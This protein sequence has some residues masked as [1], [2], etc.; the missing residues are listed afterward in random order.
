MKNILVA[1]IVFFVG[2]FAY[3]KFVGPIPFAV[4][5]VV[6]NK[7]DS[8]TVTGEGKVTVKPDIAVIT[9]G[10]Q[11]TGATVTAVQNN[12]NT[13]INNVSAA[14]KKAGVANK[15]IQTS[16]YS[17][18][19]TID[20]TDS[21]QHITGYQASSNLTIKI[22]AIDTANTVIDAATA[23]GAN[24]VG[25]ISFDVDDKTTSENEARTLA[26]ADAKKKAENAAATAGFKLGSIVNYQESTGGQTPVI[27][28]DAKMNGAGVATV[29][30]NVEQG[31]TD[32]TMT[33]TLSYEIR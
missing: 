22:R 4:N 18:N 32:I 21:K 33:V 31:S 26:V 6:T 28:M 10:V 14:V 24:S 11:T 1:I 27:R 5:S 16:N 20:Y 9:V 25:G 30:T 2:L 13:A 29:P 12:L 19:P 15:D 7:T 17:I 3:T 8:F 23:A